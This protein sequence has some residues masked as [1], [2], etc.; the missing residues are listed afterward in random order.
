VA[1]VIATGRYAAYAI[2][3]EIGWDPRGRFVDGQNREIKTIF[4]LYPWE[5]LVADRFGDH[6]LDLALSGG[7]PRDLA[8][9]RA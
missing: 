7:G 9:R 2:A 4:K 5:W 6:L 8:G 1:R 3:G